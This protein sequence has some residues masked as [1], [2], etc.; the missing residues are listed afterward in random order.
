MFMLDINAALV[1]AC[2]CGTVPLLMSF[3]QQFLFENTHLKYDIK[4]LLEIYIEV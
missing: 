2:Y 4:F 1:S 3:N